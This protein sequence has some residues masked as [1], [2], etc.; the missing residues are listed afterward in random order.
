[1][2]E[3]SVVKNKILFH[4]MAVHIADISQDFQQDSIR[5][6]QQYIQ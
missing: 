4:H 6:I 5:S 3:Q 1:M 2:R